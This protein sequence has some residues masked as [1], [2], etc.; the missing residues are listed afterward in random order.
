MCCLPREVLGSGLLA[1]T[2]FACVL[3]PV[4]FLLYRLGG[5]GVK[6]RSS[7][8]A[9][10][11]SGSWYCRWGSIHDPDGEGALS[12]SLLL[13]KGVR[14]TVHRSL[15]ERAWL[16]VVGSCSFRQQPRGWPNVRSGVRAPSLACGFL[17]QRQR[18]DPPA[19]P[20]C[21]V[22]RVLVRLVLSA[23]LL[24]YGCFRSLTLV[25]PC[26]ERHRLVSVPLWF[27]HLSVATAGPCVRFP[28]A[29]VSQEYVRSRYLRSRHRLGACSPSVLGTVPV[30]VGVRHLWWLARCSLMWSGFLRA[31]GSMPGVCVHLVL[32]DACCSVCMDVVCGHL[33]LAMTHVL[34]RGRRLYLVRYRSL[35]GDLR[36]RWWFD[37]CSLVRSVSC[38]HTAPPVSVSTCLACTCDG[39][40]AIEYTC[41]L[42]DRDGDPESLCQSS[43]PGPRIRLSLTLGV[44]DFRFRFWE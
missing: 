29:D 28:V 2:G 31:L 1:G 33:V 22:Q 8:P 43:W 27:T 26:L 23:L 36:F 16:L 21:T 38:S 6:T 34:L 20:Y 32:A 41:G 44:W 18:G 9:G 39:A 40:L 5:V 24:G 17:K 3:G 25:L 30:T 15:H 13:R 10:F 37:H 14:G 35:H 7:R 42:E 12:L 19:L 11:P 4:S